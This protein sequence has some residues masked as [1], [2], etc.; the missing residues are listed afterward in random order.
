MRNKCL[1]ST[2]YQHIGE[3]VTFI[4]T[5]DEIYFKTNKRGNYELR[6][7]E[8]GWRIVFAVEKR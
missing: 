8:T 7:I 5:L 6:N 2:R 3:L 4:K 1:K